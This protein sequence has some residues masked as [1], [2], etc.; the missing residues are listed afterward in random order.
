MTNQ[1]IGGWAF[2][3]VGLIVTGETEE[4][5]LADFFR[6]LTCQGTCN[7]RVIRRVG[8]RSPITSQKR[9]HKMVGSGKTIPDSDA[10]EIGLTARRFMTNGG[11]YVMLVDDLEFERAAHASAV[12]DRYRRALDSMLPA[13]LRGMAA[14]HFFVCMLEAYYFADSN[15][16]NGVLGT[17]CQDFDGDVETIRNP[18]A[19]LR[20]LYPG[21]DEKGHGPLIVGTL[22]VMHVLA[23]EDSCAS[24][25]TMF[26]WAI[27]AVSSAVALPDGP[28]FDVTKA[29][30]A[31]L[32]QAKKI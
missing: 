9:K 18:K 30:I 20:V 10:E 16:L 22:D 11:D 21:F 32:R 29:Q 12:F 23:R 19:N 5:C 28:L 2:S 3:R 27:E 24:L 4:Q 25:R 26:A 14:V 8:Q 31:T 7:F 17:D 1:P 13:N 15:A 6:I